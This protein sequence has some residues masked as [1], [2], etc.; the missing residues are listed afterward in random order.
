MRVILISSSTNT[1]GGARQ[2]L[3]LARGLHAQG[4]LVAFFIPR[5]SALR[6]LA[7]ELPWQDAPEGLV[8]QYR[9]LVQAMAPAFAAGEK[10][11]VHA[12]HNK[13]VKRIALFG[14]YWKLKGL[15]VVCAA[16]RGVIYPPN[17][18]LPY[19]LPGID[20]FIVNSQACADV[21][22]LLWRRKRVHVVYNA[23]PEGRL[24]TTR[25]GE[26]VRLGLHI[27]LAAPLVCCVA[28]NSANK[29]VDVLLA[30]FA[31]LHAPLAHLVVIGVT[32]PRFQAQC[33]QLGI[34][35]RVR[36]IGQT[37][38]VAD[39]LQTSTFFVVPSFSESQPNT[40]LEAMCMGLAVIG[41]R[42]GGIPELIS[43]PDLLVPPKDVDALARAMQRLLEDNT[44]REEEAA[45]N[46]A[47]GAR[48]SLAFRL[49]R[50]M[51]IYNGL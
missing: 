20:A 48:F 8:P 39:Y 13:A 22:P 24:H 46:T 25:S 14:T 17:N 7:P 30:A 42:V 23:I 19:L 34:A 5:K 1:S 26:E 36:L 40:L 16:H 18:P 2:A 43:S 50:V 6:A 3:Y 41:S 47:F 35:D 10:V 28:N 21:L 15:P 12:F 33:E 44:L 32:D 27:P 9:A 45:R 38:H 31:R 49:D 29:G 37:E 51:E 11:V 4:R